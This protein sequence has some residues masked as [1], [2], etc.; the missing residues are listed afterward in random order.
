MPVHLSTL[1]SFTEAQARVLAKYQVDP[2]SVFSG[3]GLAEAPYHDA[4]A[5]LRAP[6]VTRIWEAMVEATGNPCIGFEVGMAITPTNLHAVGYAW[7]ASRTVREA[8]TRMARYA[9]VVTTSIKAKI[10][11]EDATT[12]SAILEG[13]PKTSQESLDSAMCVIV[14]TCRVV[15][16]DDFHPRS[17]SMRRPEPPCAPELR[18]YFGCPVTFGAEQNRV[19]FDDAIIDELLPRQ[20]PAMAQASDEVA[21]QY[22]ADLDRSNVVA[23]GRVALIGML[24]NGEPH[25]SDLAARL[26][27]SDRTLARRLHDRG[28]SFR[29]LLDD[30]RSEL[31]VGYLRQPRFSIGEVAYLLGFSDQSN[32]A[33]SFKRWTG[34]A[35]KDYRLTLV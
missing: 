34:S 26:N 17:V 2:G 12:T 18:S 22:A 29:G 32:F 10:D 27:M 5:R 23:N 4:D 21:R 3:V 1:A 30:V 13:H 9:R 33:R 15:S 6:D 7:I 25:R 31:A 8:L 35:P 16:V 28:A 24:P 19:V 14:E 20:N 11:A